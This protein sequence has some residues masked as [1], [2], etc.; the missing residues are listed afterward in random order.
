MKSS[1]SHK[2]SSLFKTELRLETQYTFKGS[3][4]N[5]TKKTPARFTKCNKMPK[6]QY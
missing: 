2:L 6:L 1:I 4:I 5:A 3:L